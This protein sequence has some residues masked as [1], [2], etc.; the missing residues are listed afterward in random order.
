M[1]GD[2]RGRWF[3]RVGVVM[4]RYNLAGVVILMFTSATLAQHSSAGSG[5]SSAGSSSSGPPAGG[6]HVSSSNFSGTSGAS[7]SSVGGSVSHGSSA[8]SSSLGTATSRSCVRGSQLNPS[9]TTFAPNRGVQAKLAQPEKRSFLSFLRH[10]FRK[11]EPKPVPDL[12]R[13]I[14]LKGPCLA[15]PAGQVR[16]G[17]GC[18]ETAVAKNSYNYCSRGEIWSGGSCLLQ[19][20]FLDDCNGL[21][22]ALDQQA[23][24]M[25]A[26][27]S[28]QQA[29]CLP[30]AT[31]DCSEWTGKAQSEASLYRSLQE[32]YR[33]CQLR[34][35]DAFSYGRYGNAGQ[36]PGWLFEPAYFGVDYP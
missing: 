15:C 3:P 33:Q 20:R 36:W 9:H 27:D 4:R 28:A 19:T 7:H 12:R 11:P 17:G 8:R 10:P 31:Q 25:Q 6:S 35:Y 14:C 18:A 16:A 24:R 23:Q 32:R 22:L 1:P 21:R 29:A 34:S 30:G 26:A 2:P 5:G 13:R